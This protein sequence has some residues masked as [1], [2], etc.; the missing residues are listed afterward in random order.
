VQPFAPKG[1]FALVDKILIKKHMETG[2]CVKEVKAST[3]Q[4]INMFME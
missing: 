3:L 4:N 2:R 1:Y